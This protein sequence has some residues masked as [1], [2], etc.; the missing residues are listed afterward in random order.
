MMKY[1]GTPTLKSDSRPTF[2]YALHD[3][4]EVSQR[5]YV[6]MTRNPK[7]R[8]AAHRK[9]GEVSGT[10]RANWLTSLRARGTRPA[11]VIL[12]TVAPGGDWAEAEQFWI[13]SLRAMGVPMVNLTDGGE[14]VWGYRLPAEGRAR[15]SAQ[16]RQ[17]P[18]RSNNTTGFKGVH[19]SNETYT[20]R[21][22]PVL[23]GPYRP[24]GVYA[25]AE[26]AAVAYDR[27]ARAA[28][29]AEAA[30]NFPFPG[31]RSARPGVEPQQWEL[32]EPIRL[33]GGGS[34]VARVAVRS[35]TGYKGVG[36]ANPG[37]CTTQKYVATIMVA[38]KQR[39]IGSTFATPEE[40]ARAYDHAARAAWGQDAALNFPAPGERG[41]RRH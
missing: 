25:T 12:E 38:G 14:G 10:F 30:L 22:R 28:W 1:E 27:A 21:I 29:G 9:P 15:W 37:R 33:N 7:Q 18:I 6:G 35:K 39:V 19:L 13:A 23:A 41:A 20:A 31:E 2:I 32:V 5:V 17:A 26:E 3:P 16:R 36:L 34:A 40:A 11:M 8:Y 4:S 24:L